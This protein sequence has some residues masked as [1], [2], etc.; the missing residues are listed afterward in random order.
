MN[1]REL[2]EATAQE[3]Y[4]QLAL[5]FHPDRGG[6]Q[7]KMAKLNAAKD[8]GN[9]DKIKAMYHMVV[10]PDPDEDEPVEKPQKVSQLY[11]LYKQWA[12]QIEEELAQRG[13]HGIKIT[14][15]LQGTSAN[16][17]VFWLINGVKRSV[18]IPKIERFRRKKDFALEVLRKFQ[19]NK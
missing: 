17:W 5:K 12:E 2:I 19:Q 6:D 10:E 9:W 16:A 3:M 15:E 8:E 7:E 11:K 4:R 14:I 1:I 13:S 18:Y